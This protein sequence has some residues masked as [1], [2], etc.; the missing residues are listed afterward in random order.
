[1]RARYDVG[2]VGYGP[3]GQTPGR[4]GWPEANMFAQPELEHLLDARARALATVDVPRGHEA[5]GVDAGVTL[6][7][8]TRDA[9]RHFP[10]RIHGSPTPVVSPL[11]GAT[12]FVS[13]R[14]FR[15]PHSDFGRP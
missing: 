15:A 10:D 14:G 3:V 8:T 5:V 1:M 2:I 13:D 9:E 11:Y 12:E 7:L 4:S 6:Q